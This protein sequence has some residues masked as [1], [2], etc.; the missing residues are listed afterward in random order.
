MRLV[1]SSVFFLMINIACAADIPTLEEESDAYDASMCVQNY[2][3]NCISTVCITSED[4]NCEEHCQTE[5]KARC[6]EQQE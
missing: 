1:S 5:A 2:A 4:I 6:E 3:D